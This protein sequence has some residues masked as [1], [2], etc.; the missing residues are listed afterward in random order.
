MQEPTKIGRVFTE[1]VRGIELDAT[2]H[3]WIGSESIDVLRLA[4]LKSR[5]ATTPVDALVRTLPCFIINEL[6]R[7]LTLH[8]Q[9]WSAPC[10]P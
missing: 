7:Q 5:E 10:A 9:G 6:Q 4:V 2:T 3:S 1:C 8:V